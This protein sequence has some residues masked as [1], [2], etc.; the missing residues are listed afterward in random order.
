MDLASLRASVRVS[1]ASQVHLVRIHQQDIGQQFS[2][3]FTRLLVA[4][5]YVIALTL[6]P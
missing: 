6:R 4:F 2:V 3:V 5:G 1:Q